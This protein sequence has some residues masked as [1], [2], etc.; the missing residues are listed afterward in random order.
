MFPSFSDQ[1]KSLTHPHNQNTPGHFRSIHQHTQNKFLKTT[2]KGQ[3]SEPFPPISTPRPFLPAT[4]LKFESTMGS[5]WWIL[6]LGRTEEPVALLDSALRAGIGRSFVTACERRALEI[7]KSGGSSLRRD[8]IMAILLYTLVGYI[9]IN[10]AL[11]I[12]DPEVIRSVKG[13]IFQTLAGLRS[14]PRVQVNRL[15]SIMESHAD[16]RCYH[17]GAEIT[18]HSFSSAVQDVTVARDLL[19]GGD[20]PGTLFIING[21]TG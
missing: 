5:K 1:C 13:L 6:S 10:L 9:P 20:E 17:P 7:V 8:S 11:S 16:L 15:F 18:W 2:K 12:R 21:A 19:A 3:N 4:L 14:L